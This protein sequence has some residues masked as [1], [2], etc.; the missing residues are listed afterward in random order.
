MTT[1]L[2]VEDGVL[3]IVVGEDGPIVAAAAAGAIEKPRLPRSRPLPWCPGCGSRGPPC[4]APK[5]ASPV[6]TS[7][8]SPYGSPFRL[9]S[10]PRVGSAPC[11]RQGLLDDPVGGEVDTRGKAD[12]L[13]LVPQLDGKSGLPNLCDETRERREPGLRGERGGLAFLPKNGQEAA[14]L[15]QGLAPRLL[16]GEQRLAF[17]LLLGREQPAYGAGLNRHHA[18][19]MGDDIVELAGDSPAL[20]LDRAQGVGGGQMLDSR[21]RRAE[22]ASDELR[23]AE[24]HEPTVLNRG[25]RGV[26]R[27]DDPRSSLRRRPAPL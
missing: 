27:G 4:W 2:E 5:S 13:A 22:E 8:I 21:L 24:A 12:L 7:P 3:V 26:I 17:A 11:V 14:H 16:D 9:A 10:P 20:L 25:S 1:G 6:V 18:D 19:R 15:G 23:Q